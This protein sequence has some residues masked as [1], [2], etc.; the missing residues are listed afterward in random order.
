MTFKTVVACLTTPESA[1]AVSASALQLASKHDAFLIGL[2]AI[3]RVAVYGLIGA[4][5][6][7]E[8]IER[9]EEALRERA[10]EVEKLF[11]DAIEKAGKHAKAKTEWRCVQSTRSIISTAALQR[12][13]CADLIVMGQF[14]DGEDDPEP[15]AE[16]VLG[17]GRPVLLIPHRIPPKTIGERIVVAWNGK[18][19]AERAAF[20]ALPILRQAKKVRVLTMNPEDLLGRDSLESAHDFVQAL[21]RHGVEASTMTSNPKEISLGD[22]LLSRLADES[23]DL[24]VMGCYGHSRIRELIFGGVTRD[25]LKSMTVPVLMSH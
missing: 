17:V 16:I 1:P 6:P 21:S 25:I 23:C 9:E 19:E 20:D 15:T 24:L 5:M 7:G 4:E 11:T 2:H 14:P 22:D 18:R 10:A 12:M 3:P 13:P 8:V